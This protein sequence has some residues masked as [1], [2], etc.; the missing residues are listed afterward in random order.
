MAFKKRMSEGRSRAVMPKA[1]I[2]AF[3]RLE[4]NGYYCF[5]NASRV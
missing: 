2:V 4:K 3:S 1:G 5:E